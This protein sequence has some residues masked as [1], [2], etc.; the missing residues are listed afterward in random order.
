M[1]RLSDDTALITESEME[2]TGILKIIKETIQ[3]ELN[4]K[5]NAKKLKILVRSRENS[6]RTIIKLKGVTVVERLRNLKYLES[7]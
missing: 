3:T 7:I 6:M 2:L 1:L 5:S 4:M